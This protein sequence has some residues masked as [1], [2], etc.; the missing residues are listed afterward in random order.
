VL[1]DGN[2]YRLYFIIIIYGDSMSTTIQVKKRNLKLLEK[3]KSQIGARSYDELIEKL[4]L[5]KLGLEGDMFGVD[6]GKISSF[7]EKDRMEDR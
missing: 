5:E 1:A 3:L 6:R 4:V 7:S 2:V